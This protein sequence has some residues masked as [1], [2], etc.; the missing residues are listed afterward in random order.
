MLDR[1]KQKNAF[2]IIFKFIVRIW[3][4]VKTYS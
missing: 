4:N 2:K 1:N 3:K